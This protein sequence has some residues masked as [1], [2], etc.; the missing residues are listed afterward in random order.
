M[1]LTIII[2][3]VEAGAVFAKI[4]AISATYADNTD[5]ADI[6]SAA[7]FSFPLLQLFNNTF[8]FGFNYRYTQQNIEA[9]FSNQKRSDIFTIGG[10]PFSP[11]INLEQWLEDVPNRMATIERSADPIHFAISPSRFPELPI[12]LVRDVSEHLLTATDRYYRVNTRRGCVD[13]TAAN[14]DFQANFGDSTLCVTSSFFVDMAFG[15]VFQRCNSRGRDNVCSIRMFAQPNPFTGGY[16]CPAGYTEVQLLSGTDSYVGTYTS[17]YETCSFFG[18][19]CSTRSN[20]QTSISYADYQTFWCV[21]INPAEE[22][23]RYLFG[24]F[25]TPT[26]SNPVT[27]TLSC[28]PYFRE[29]NVARD[30]TFCNVQDEQNLYNNNNI[31]SEQN[32]SNN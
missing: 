28:P 10:A 12:Q 26:N 29:Q 16:S 24:G 27:G 18:I 13:P 22:Y 31:Q 7:S 2:T 30:V 4:D 17:Y 20:T 23:R 14:F 15:G 21:A 8:N 6:T 32:D 9:Y 25:F 3:T 11:Q 19:F 1:V 5:I